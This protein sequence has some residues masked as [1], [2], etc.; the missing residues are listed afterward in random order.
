MGPMEKNSIGGHRFVCIFTCNY[1]SHFWVFLLKSKDQTL[2]KFKIFV[3]VIEKSTSFKIKYFHLD[4]GGE[5]MSDQ[6]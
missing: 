5:F 1:S 4:Q 3:L 6:L 2:S